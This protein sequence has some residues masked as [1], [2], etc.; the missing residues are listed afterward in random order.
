MTLDLGCQARSP[1]FV[2]GLEV[3]ADKSVLAAEAVVEAGLR[4]A[5]ALDD[6]VDADSVDASLVEQLARRGQ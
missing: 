1:C 4:D 3:G 2:P 5:G 6:R